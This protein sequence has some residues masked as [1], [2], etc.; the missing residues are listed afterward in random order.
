MVFPVF[1]IAKGE[2]TKTDLLKILSWES[3]TRTKCCSDVENNMSKFPLPR[4]NYTV[5]IASI[6]KV[7]AKPFL[8]TQPL[9]LLST[10]LA[11]S[12]F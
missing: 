9:Y 3:E 10:I 12:R 1:F 2:S 6:L 11:S 8:L 4:S 7:I 5:G